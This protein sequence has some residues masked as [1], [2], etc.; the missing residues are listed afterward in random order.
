MAN[1]FH[2]G[3]FLGNGFGVYAWDDTWRGTQ[4]RD[5]YKPA[6]YQ[7]LARSLERACFDFVMLEDGSFVPDG[8]GGSSELYLKLPT[9]SPKLDPAVTIPLMSEV[10]SRLGLVPTLSTSEYPPFLLARLVSTLDHISEGRAGWNVVTSR[11]QITGENFGTHFPDKE[12]R[13]AIADEYI[14]LVKKL[15]NSWER[16][17]IIADLERG[18]FADHTK[19]HRV[20]HVGEH[21]R[22]R[23]PLNAPHMPQGEPVIVQ[24]GQSPTGRQF[25]AKNADAVVG[26]GNGV[27]A[28]KAYRDDLSERMLSV[29]RKPADL[30][31]MYLI[32]PVLGETNEEAQERSKRWKQFRQFDLEWGLALASKVSGIDWSKFELD[33]P[34][35]D[36]M[37]V[38]KDGVWQETA[39]PPKQYNPDGTEMTVRQ[40]FESKGGGQFRGSNSVE[41][42]GTPDAVAGQMG[43]AMEEIG[44]DGFLLQNLYVTRRYVSEICDGLIP[45]LQRRG[46]TRTG[47]TNEHFRDN[48]KEF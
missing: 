18:V 32:M 14:E 21:F 37:Q 17:A 47:Y 31:L 38:K 22:S 39:A 5:W 36:V 20:D 6:F 46:L 1:P 30:K 48:L 45:E 28:L 44:G 19:V 34:M 35:P 25:A 4:A 9:A 42:V 10:T 8:Y 43:E 40:T 24:A 11:T 2:L 15:W 3:W 23:G 27:E 12:D 29:G 26:I 13:Y 7:D 16:D 41:F 33:E